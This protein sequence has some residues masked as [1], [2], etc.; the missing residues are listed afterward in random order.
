LLF[1]SLRKRPEQWFHPLPTGEGRVRVLTYTTL[2][3]GYPFKTAVL[4]FTRI[5]LLDETD[6]DSKNPL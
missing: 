3:F 1:P 6:E 4:Y 5:G 2:M